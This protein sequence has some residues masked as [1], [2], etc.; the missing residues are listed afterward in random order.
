MKTTKLS[1]LIM[2]LAII[3]SLA[4]FTYAHWSDTIRIEGTMKMAHI[5]IGIKS[6]K[7]LISQY[8]KKQY[9]S[10]VEWEVSPDEHTLEINS[11][12]LGPCWYIWVGLVMQNQGPR[13]G[14]IKPPEYVFEDEYGFGDYFETT[15]Y[16]YGPYPENTGF[17][18]LEVWGKVKID[19]QLK[20]DGA[21]GFPTEVP[22]PTPFTLDPTEKAVTWIW[23]H[24]IE[25]VPP[26]ATGETVILY[27]N[28][29]D[30][31]AI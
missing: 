22:T 23:I 2:T 15:E 18:D 6:G 8:V 3:I 30:D 17:G 13:P 10:Y 14:Q 5:L 4:G 26:T 11:T 24:V 27:I 9:K 1:A 7:V 31:I 25:G 12:N 28:I 19:E 20:P 29:V 21:V 16:F